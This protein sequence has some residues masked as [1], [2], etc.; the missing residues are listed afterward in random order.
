MAIRSTL[1]GGISATAFSIAMVA[2]APQA[3]FAQD[4]GA[5]ADDAEA[6]E[7]DGDVIIVSGFRQALETAVAEKRLSDQILESVTAEDIGKLPDEY[8]PV[9]IL[10][11]V[12]GLTSR[13]VGKI[14]DLSIPAVKSR[15]KT[16][17]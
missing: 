8:R 14:L 3:A 16:S 9:F 13:E 10:R 17:R 11:D 15:K 4:A 5:P 12:D 1:A 6:T 7:E 2:A